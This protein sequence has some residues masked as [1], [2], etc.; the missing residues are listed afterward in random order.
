VTE[1]TTDPGEQDEEHDQ[2]EERRADGVHD[3]LEVTLVLS[4]LDER[5]SATDERVLS[6]G[7]DDTVGLSALATS[8]VVSD[9]AH[10]LVDSER[11]TG[12]GRL[13]ASNEGN[14]L[15]DRVL[16]VELLL[17]ELIL[18]LV[19]VTVVELVLS[20]ELKVELEVLRLVV[21]A[22][23]T[24]VT[25]HG[26]TLL[27]DNDVTGNELTGEDGLLLVVTDDSRL[28]GDVT[29][30]RGDDIGGLLFLVPTDDSVEKKNTANDTE[31][32]PVLKTGGEKGSKFH[33]VENRTGEV[34]HELLQEVGLLRGDFVVAIALAT[35]F[36][37]VSGETGAKL[38]IDEVV[39]DLS[40]E[41]S[42]ARGL[43]AAGLPPLLLLGGSSW[44]WPADLGSR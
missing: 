10:V 25:G 6:S 21:V 39:R 2:D 15:G 28:H 5:S 16:L 37:L 40:S 8:G 22:D 1:E 41:V 11:F 18:L 33:N 23:K 20:L 34:T 32:D 19:W 14:T 38:S 43:A 27:D 36:G 12:D 3:S 44:A 42:T 30:E 24:N 31:I 26:G 9:L 17:V 7:D 29:L 35:A 4:A 13:I